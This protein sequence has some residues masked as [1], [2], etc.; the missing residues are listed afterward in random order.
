MTLTPHVVTELILVAT[1]VM[2]A[3]KPFEV[4]PLGPR[5]L[6]RTFLALMALG[7]SFGALVYAGVELAEPVA[8]MFRQ[9]AGT[10]GAVSFVLGAYWLLIRPPRPL[11]IAGV[12]LIMWLAAAVVMNA[13]TEIPGVVVRVGTMAAVALIALVAL[14]RR[15]LAATAML[16]VAGGFAGSAIFQRLDGSLLGLSGVDVYHLLLAGSVVAMAFAARCAGDRSAPS[17]VQALS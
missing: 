3:F 11:P 1:C 15:R 7:A 5:R 14:P 17:S 12:F 2:V 9:L 4:L 16:M 6:W 13:A 8:D 10:V